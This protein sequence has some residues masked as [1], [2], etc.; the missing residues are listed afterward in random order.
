VLRRVPSLLGGALLLGCIALAL[1]ELILQMGSLFARDRERTSAATTARRVL[2]V[3][4]SHTY[5]AMVAP[6]ESYPGQLQRL[7]DERAPG[8]WS[9]VN[10]G[11]PG[12][13]TAQVRARLQAALAA[14]RPDV[15]LVWCGV[16]NAWNRWQATGGT[17]GRAWLDRSLANLRTYRLLRVWWHDR[18][19]DRSV[20]SDALTGGRRFE[21]VGDPDIAN[22]R[23]SF[24]V[25]M[26]DETERIEHQEGD[27]RAD[28]EMQRQVEGDIRGMVEDL[29]TAGVPVAL[30]AYP[31]EEDAFALANAAMRRIGVQYGVPVLESGR[32]AARV[33][34]E[35]R[36]LLW[37]AHPTGPIYGEV[38]RDL[39]PIV[40]ASTTIAAKG[41]GPDRR[42]ARLAFDDRDAKA[43][44]TTL[45]GACTRTTTA[46]RT[47][48]GCYLWDPRA[49]TC[50]ARQ[51]LR[52]RALAVQATFRLRVT[53]FPRAAGGSEIFGLF[54]S[55]YGTG[56]FVQ[57]TDAERL[58][59]L[60]AGRTPAHCGPVPFRLEK[61]TWY[62]VRVR[63]EKAERAHTALELSSDDGRPLGAVACDGQP[64]GSG[65]FTDVMVGNT[66]PAGLTAEIRFDDVEVYA[67]VRPAT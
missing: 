26:G 45:T 23:Q 1:A 16:N 33:P 66:N 47:A 51:P 57:L 35:E 59:L 12:L 27:F 5:G 13:N 30:I 43:T 44:G 36:K 9:V 39:V 7:L 21:I 8:E 34:R 11:I 22:P 53:E 29:R 58:R 19:I 64:T 62:A 10:L 55:A 25:R 31:V 18:Q 65:A 42:L 38:A 3:G 50:V 40:L 28:P 14:H 2:C 52:A 63:A 60:A 54:E 32:S 48:A 41:T 20:P 37:A 61:D 56:L 6:E 17:G 4:D 49:A 15:V 67:D 46:C 24:T